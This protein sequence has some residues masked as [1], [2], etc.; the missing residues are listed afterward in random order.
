MAENI[1]TGRGDAQY[2]LRFPEGMRERIKQAA[3]ANGRS[4]NVEI[5]ARLEASF[6]TENTLA[7]ALAK[8]LDD[9]IEQQVNARLR[10]IAAKI[11]GA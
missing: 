4:M 3:D 11:G 9:H 1:K 10:A 5:T 7:P 8:M 6:S 2:M